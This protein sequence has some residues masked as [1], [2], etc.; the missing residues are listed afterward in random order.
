MSLRSITA[1]LLTMVS[2]LAAGCL[3]VPSTVLV[4]GVLHGD[5]QWEGEVRLAGDVLLAPDARLTIRPGTQVL[6]L[7]PGGFPGGLTEHP[8]FAGSELIIQGHLRAEGTADAPIVFRA[9]NPA[10]AAGSWG[11]LNLEEGGEGYF[12][13]CIFRQADSAIHGSESSIVVTESLFE[14]NLVGLRFHSS[15]VL[16]THNLWRNNGTAIRFHFGAPEISGNRCEGNRRNLF[17]TAHPTDYRIE[18]N[19]FGKAAEY[20]VV[21]GEEVPDDFLLAR[22]AWE[23]TSLAELQSEMYDGRQVTYL[24]KV[25]VEPLL[26]AP[27]EGVGPSWIR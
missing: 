8:H 24:G 16:A 23:T 18:N 25:L 4:S 11:A 19:L 9:A 20:Q 13:H 5:L 12:S 15:A 14:N 3:A 2:L 21:L 27:P 26:L 22:N 6:F 17:V 7:P 10:A 1:G